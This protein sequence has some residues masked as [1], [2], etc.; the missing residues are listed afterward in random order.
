[1]EYDSVLEDRAKLRACI[2]SVSDLKDFL[3]DVEINYLKLRDLHLSGVCKEN[4]LD[5]TLS[6]VVELKILAVALLN[7]YQV[8]LIVTTGDR[9][10]RQY[11]DSSLTSLIK[12]GLPVMKKVVDC[13]KKHKFYFRSGSPELNIEV[14]D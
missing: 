8:D 2:N 13:Y 9:H 7:A 3:C 11:Q 1:M 6:D 10:N 12:L 4:C 14:S 5:L